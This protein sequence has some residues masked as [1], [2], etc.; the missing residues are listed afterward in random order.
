MS[1]HLSGPRAALFLLSASLITLSACSKPAEEAPA[2]EETV[3][4]DAA[5]DTAAH[6]AAR[7]ETP[8]PKVDPAA[9]PQLAYDYHFDLSAPD[10]K[11][12]AS[13]GGA[14]GSL[15]GCRTGDVSGSVAKQPHPREQRQ[16]LSH[17]YPARHPAMDRYFPQKSG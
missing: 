13:D 14:S 10:K 11:I 3:P 12:T 4:A 8:S 2:L 5:A 15:H 17:P 1:R 7:A 16:R 9:L 6:T